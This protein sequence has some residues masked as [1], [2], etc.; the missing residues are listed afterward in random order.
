MLKQKFNSMMQ[1]KHPAWGHLDQ[2]GFQSQLHIQALC[3]WTDYL[4]LPRFRFLV[5]RVKISDIFLYF[6]MGLNEIL[7]KSHY[8]YY[9]FSQFL[10]EKKA[11]LSTS[12]VMIAMW[13]LKHFTHAKCVTNRMY[14]L[15]VKINLIHIYIL[16]FSCNI[17]HSFQGFE[18]NLEK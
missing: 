3:S 6:V 2:R 4:S 1:G 9:E 15:Q 8:I 5:F 17:V 12:K 13:K 18:I 10:R 14:I 7:Y 11:F 16:Y